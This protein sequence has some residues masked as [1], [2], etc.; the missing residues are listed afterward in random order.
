MEVQGRIK[1]IFET[2]EYGNNGFQVRQ[3]VVTTEEQYPQPLIIDFVQD[4]T[5][6]LDNYQKGQLVKIG[7]N[8]RGR[9]WVSPQGETKYFVSLSGWRIQ[10][11]EAQQPAP[12][13]VPP[14]EDFEP[15]THTTTDFDEDDEDDLPF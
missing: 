13:Q 12:G 2:K 5:N 7:I 9:E 14:P 11:V 8:L 3:V 15:I 10:N 6:L 4:K 1:E